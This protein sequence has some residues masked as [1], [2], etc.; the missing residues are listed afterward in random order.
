MTICHIVVLRPPAVNSCRRMFTFSWILRF[1]RS[2][3]NFLSIG[4]YTNFMKRLLFIFILSLL[5]FGAGC[6]TLQQIFPT[7]EPTAVP[8]PTPIPT[9]SP[10]PTPRPVIAVV[11]DEIPAAFMEGVS[12]AADNAA[13]DVVYAAGS[14]ESLPADAI[15]GSGI[16]LLVYTGNTFD[17][18]A[19]QALEKAAHPVFVYAPNLSML[20]AKI[21]ALTHQ[22]KDDAKNA[23]DDALSYPPHDTPVRLVGLFESETSAAAALYQ[24]YVADGKVLAKKVYYRDSEKKTVDEW[25]ADLLERCFP[26]MLDGVYVENASLAIAILNA[27][28]TAERSDFEIFSASVNDELLTR[29]LTH[30]EIVVHAVGVNPMYAGTASI[31]QAGSLLQ[32]GYAESFALSSVLFQSETLRENWAALVREP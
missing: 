13:Y 15:P 4:W 1:Y 22:G 24:Q 16:Y 3:W 17:I 30:P 12:A 14:A 20:P 8:T 25:A 23:L 32:N 27:M 19:Q 11:S 2:L 26:G 18:K 28:A 29:M 21:P 6:Q 10:S 7:P 9:P 5:C 31:G